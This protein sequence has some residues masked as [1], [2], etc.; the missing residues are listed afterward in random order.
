V[1]ATAEAAPKADLWDYWLAHDPDAATI[2]DHTP[3]ESLLKKYVKASSDGIN[4]V[5]YARVTSKDKELLYKYISSLERIGLSGLNRPEQKAFWINLYNALTIQVI[6]DHYPVKSIKD[7]NISPGLFRFG[8]WDKGLIRIEGKS[9][10]LND[11]EHRILRPIWKDSRIHYA[12]NCASLGCPNLSPHAYTAQNI[13]E[14]LD[15]AA[16]EYINHPR[17]VSLKS[18]KLHVSSIYSWFKEDFGNSDEGV[19]KHLMQYSGDPLRKQLMNIKKI[20]GDDYDWSL[21]D[22]Q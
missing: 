15:S 7:I 16:R 5:S 18:G 17:G 10:T 22:V 4:R 20:S 8:P 12:V 2:V 3:W 14:M 9:L 6:I 19:I 21:N 1:F 13:N 11:I